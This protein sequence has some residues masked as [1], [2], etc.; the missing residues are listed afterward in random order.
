MPYGI[1]QLKLIFKDQKTFAKK[2][3]AFSHPPPWSTFA[4][5][6]N[7]GRACCA[8]KNYRSVFMI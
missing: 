6:I 4:R 7:N 2:S 1:I 5:S 3:A 8:E